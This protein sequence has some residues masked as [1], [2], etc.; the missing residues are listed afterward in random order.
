[1]LR[2]GRVRVVL[3]VLTARTAGSVIS[4]FDAWYRSG[5]RKIS[6]AI[7]TAALIACSDSSMAAAMS[8]AVSARL[9]AILAATSS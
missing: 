9:T 7:G 2:T 4:S 5:S 6:P 8:A 1:L 3:A